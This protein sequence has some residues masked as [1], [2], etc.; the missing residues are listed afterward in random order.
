MHPADPRC[1]ADR[2]ASPPAR[3]C[4]AT[5]RSSA[6]RHA[7]S[8]SP[9]CASR[10]L[11]GTPDLRTDSR[12]PS[13]R[14]RRTRTAA[15]RQA[16]TT[17]AP[18][19]W[20]CA[21]S[22][23]TCWCGRRSLTTRRAGR[24]A[25]ASTASPTSS[26]TRPSASLLQSQFNALAGGRQQC[27]CPASQRHPFDSLARSR[28]RRSSSLIPSFLPLAAPSAPCPHVTLDSSSCCPLL[29]A[30]PRR[31]YTSAPQFYLPSSLCALVPVLWSPKLRTLGPFVTRNLHA[32]A[33]SS[34][35]RRAV[36]PS[37]VE[38]RHQYSV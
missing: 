17:G 8:P 4:V 38:P 36:T 32:L 33:A 3:S 30:S 10:R 7:S 29:H 35:L 21:I 27:G 11:D 31:T 25:L 34:R 12:S 16:A 18:S 1:A 6:F 5:R 14:R 20:P 24:T 13:A 26:T 19:R 15:T 23:P 2:M 37:Q 28:I 9:H 22:R